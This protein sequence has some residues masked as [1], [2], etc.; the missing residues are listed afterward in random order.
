MHPLGRVS[1]PDEVA[2]AIAY[3]ASDDASAVVGAELRVD[4]GLLAGVGV[5]LPE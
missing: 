3:L 2:S 4:G 5:E 1:T